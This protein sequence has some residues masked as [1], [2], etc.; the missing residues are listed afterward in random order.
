M[1]QYWQL[2]CPE[3][4]LTF[5]NWGK[6]GES[7]FD[8]TPEAIIERIAIP[9]PGPWVRAKLSPVPPS[10]PDSASP[11]INLPPELL[12]EIIARLPLQDLFVLALC[13]QQLYYTCR[14]RIVSILASLCGQ[15]AGT[16]LICVGDYLEP[17]DYP[18]GIDWM[19]EIE[20]LEKQLASILDN[21]GEAGSEDEDEYDDSFRSAKANP[22][23]NSYA[24]AFY[25]V[26]P[27][28]LGASRNMIAAHGDDNTWETVYLNS[29]KYL[30]DNLNHEY[31]HLSFFVSRSFYPKDLEWVLRNL[32]TKEYV[33]HSVVCPSAN[34]SAPFS[35][36]RGVGLGHFLLSRICWS[37]DPSTA[38]S[39]DGIHRGIWAGHKFD[40]T[41][42]KA[43]EGDDSWKDVSIEG[44]EELKAIWKSEYGDEWEERLL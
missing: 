28:E 5:G 19:P 32:T 33:R 21:E 26:V 37:S 35:S 22:N 10:F 27:D 16:S 14:S 29:G 15:L 18:P 42:I 41:T 17:G 6:L 12:N 24:D 40:I 9:Q 31:H 8:G 44:Y 43:I 38:M 36:Y 34:A 2:I 30:P 1:G 13:S 39:W 4:Q 7:L 11:L 23:L 25:E 3:L 20:E